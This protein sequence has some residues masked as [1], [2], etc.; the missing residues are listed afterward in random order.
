MEVPRGPGY[1]VI[2]LC[3][4]SGEGD[5]ETGPEHRGPSGGCSQAPRLGSRRFGARRTLRPRNLRAAALLAA[6]AGWGC[7]ELRESVVI[8]GDHII[9]QTGRNEFPT[10]GTFRLACWNAAKGA[11]PLAAG[12]LETLRGDHAVI[13]IQEFSE[14]LVEPGSWD[15]HGCVFARSHRIR[16]ADITGVATLSMGSLGVEQVV[17]LPAPRRELG[18]ATPKMSLATV[19]RVGERELLVINLH[20]LNFELFGWL[21][22][23]VESVAALARDHEG[24]AIVVGDFNT[25]SRSRLEAVRSVLGDFR[26]VEPTAYGE[27]ESL[28]RRGH[29][30]VR[31]LGGDPNLA[32][33]Q[34]FL[35]GVELVEARVLELEGSD[36]APLSLTLRW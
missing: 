10:S 24:P 28:R 26:W 36:H 9:L 11:D 30:L 1:G 6:L 32:L 29:T 35:R 18:F 7:A 4:M 20:G 8:F 34:V 33:D 23:Q 15:S 27:S 12:T 5:E 2:T 19:H 13:C 14:A 17:S 16:N 31:P 21:R 22:G 3:P 25:W